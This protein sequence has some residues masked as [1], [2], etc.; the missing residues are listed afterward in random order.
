MSMVFKIC[1]KWGF[2]W[3]TDLNTLPEIHFFA[4]A[5]SFETIQQLAIACNKIFSWDFTEECFDYNSLF[6][7]TPTFDISLSIISSK[8]VCVKRANHYTSIENTRKNVNIICI[9]H[10]DENINNIHMKMCNIGIRC[11]NEY[12]II[13][14]ILFDENLHK[15]TLLIKNK[16]VDE[17]LWKWI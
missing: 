3:I 16:K 12:Q 8:R 6:K 13:H 10:C 14:K 15:I 5:T 17:L 9:Y 1:S 7:P 2:F 4:T 11:E